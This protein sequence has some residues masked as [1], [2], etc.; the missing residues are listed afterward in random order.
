M[1]KTTLCLLLLVSD[2]ALGGTAFRI[3]WTELPSDSLGYPT[4]TRSS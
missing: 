3:W 4:Y 1:R 2:P